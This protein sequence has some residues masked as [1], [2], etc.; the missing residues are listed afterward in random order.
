[1]GARGPKPVPTAI[2]LQRGTFRADRAVANEARP[3]GKP[4][5]P[6]WLNADAK[7]EFRRVVKMLS[8]MG[9]IGAVDGN[10]IIRYATTWVR[11]RQALQMIEKAGEVSVYKDAE[12]KVKAI[13][14]SAFA[15]IIRGL[16]EELSR[17]ET[18]FGMNPSARS[19][20]E[21][22]MPPAGQVDTKERFFNLPLRLEVNDLDS[23]P[24]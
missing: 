7:K 16:S 20:I 6:K 10:A 19:R 4:T 13:Q 11:W 14:P 3:I 22:T 12:G 1:M 17:I 15:S 21:V 9:L 5:C 2:K 8:A 24:N 23:R 18:A